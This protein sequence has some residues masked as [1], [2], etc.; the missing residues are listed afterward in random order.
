[1]SVDSD[2]VRRCIPRSQSRRGTRELIR[3]S[4]VSGVAVAAALVV[5]LAVFAFVFG[6]LSQALDPV[7]GVV[8]ELTPD[9][10]PS[11]LFIEVGTV[12]AALTLVLLVGFLV[13]FG[14]GDGRVVA[15]FDNVMA[16]ITGIGSVHA[17]SDKMT[18]LLLN[19]H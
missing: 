14:L 8:Q 7:V 16:A 19:S 17:S 2:W 18:E 10:N 15:Q 1:M 11:A 9:R 6:T 12:L 4:F 3:R 13:E 5:T